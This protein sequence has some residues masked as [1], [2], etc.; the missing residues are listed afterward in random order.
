[1]NSKDSITI[2]RQIFPKHPRSMYG[3]LKKNACEK[4][5]SDMEKM[6]QIELIIMNFDE[7]SNY[8]ETLEQIAKVV[9]NE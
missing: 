1:M 5:I 4:A 9:E 6:E 8:Y 2:L 3:V 7:S